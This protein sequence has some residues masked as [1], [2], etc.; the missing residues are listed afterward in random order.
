MMN[1]LDGYMREVMNLK[2]KNTSIF[3]FRCFYPKRFK[4]HPKEQVFE[5]LEAPTHLS[6]N[7]DQ[8]AKNMLKSLFQNNLIELKS[9]GYF[10]FLGMIN[11][12]QLQALPEWREQ[13]YYRAQTPICI[14]CR[15]GWW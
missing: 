15:Y 8:G 14:S 11:Q 7:I 2:V 5:L 10:E 13:M 3:A 9:G 4:I 12:V 6:F 1:F